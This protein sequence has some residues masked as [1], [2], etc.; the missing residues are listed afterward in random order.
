[1]ESSSKLFGFLEKDA[2]LNLGI[3]AVVV[4]TVSGVLY[5][6]YAT[7]PDCEPEP[8]DSNQTMLL[9]SRDSKHNSSQQ[10]WR[11]EMPIG[12]F[13]LADLQRSQS[14][15]AAGPCIDH[16]NNFTIPLEGDNNLNLL[17]DAG[18]VGQSPHH[19]HPGAEFQCDWKVSEV[20]EY[21]WA[22]T[23]IEAISPIA[24]NPGELAE[25]ASAQLPRERRKLSYEARREHFIQVSTEGQMR[26]MGSSHPSDSCL[27]AQ[28]MSEA[29]DSLDHKE[30]SELTDHPTQALM[31]SYDQ[32]L[33]EL[34]RT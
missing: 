19:N 30:D 34:L 7:E 27:L 23:D 16:P 17:R 8:K 4:A 31:E 14:G 29:K 3:G 11:L 22:H 6:L 10:A 12:S 28:D 33:A 24:S 32:E 20:T 21:P 13:A 9:H 1:M 2:A 26:S 15:A 25:P 18:L 5:F